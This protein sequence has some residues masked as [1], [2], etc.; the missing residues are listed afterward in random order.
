MSMG[1]SQI[2]VLITELGMENMS[3][4]DQEKIIDLVSKRLRNVMINTLISLM[5]AEQKQQFNDALS[6]NN[7]SDE[8]IAEIVAAVPNAELM[9][10]AAL[11]HEFG[12]IKQ[13]IDIK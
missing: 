3:A 7:I 1:E 12:V 13:V 11:E 5:T 4:E 8:R 6:Q 9:I 2:S 10:Q